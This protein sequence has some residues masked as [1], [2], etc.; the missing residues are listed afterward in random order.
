[1]PGDDPLLPRRGADPRQ[2]P[3]LA[4]GR[5]RAARATRSRA[6]TSWWSSPPASR[7]ARA[8]SSARTPARSSSRSQRRLLEQAPERWIAQQTVALSTVPTVLPDGSLAPRHVDLR[9]FA[10]FGDEIKIVPGGLTRVALRE[11]SMIVNSSQ[12]GGSKDTWVLADELTVAGARR[13]GRPARPAHAPGHAPGGLA[14]AGAATAAGAAADARPDRP[15]RVLARPP[16]RA[17]RAHRAHARRPLP[18]RPA[19]PRST[20]RPRS[21]CPGTRCSR[22]WA[23]AAGHAGRGRAARRGR[24]ACSRP[25]PT[26]RSRSSPASSAAREGARTLRDTISAEMWESVNTFDL[27]LQP[28]RP[29]RRPAHRALLDLRATSRSAARCSGA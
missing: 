25:T 15:R 29:R 22:S 17:R 11:G 26:T 28:A 21:R 8:C 3:D 1:M 16:P 20:T 19:G 18:R 27:Q 10:V 14:R 13:A 7:A 9:P 12:G 2:P 24:R 4:A 6:C 5:P 23:P